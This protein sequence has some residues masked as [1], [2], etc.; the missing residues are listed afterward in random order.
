MSDFVN[1]GTL[2]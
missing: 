1:K 2:T